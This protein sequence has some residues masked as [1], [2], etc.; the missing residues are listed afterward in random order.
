MYNVGQFCALVIL[1]STGT[2]TQ[3]Q[4]APVELWRRY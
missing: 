3:T 1:L 4:N 2:Y